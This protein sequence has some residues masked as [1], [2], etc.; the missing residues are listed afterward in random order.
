MVCQV[1]R[2]N[3]CYQ[4]LVGEVMCTVSALCQPQYISRM[5]H[6]TY[7]KLTFMKYR[8][9]CPQILGVTAQNTF[10]HIFCLKVERKGTLHR[11]S[12]QHV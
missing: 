4:K 9:C 6:S 1:L 7:L 3:K 8:Q 11:K 12:T 5:V 10:F 2:A